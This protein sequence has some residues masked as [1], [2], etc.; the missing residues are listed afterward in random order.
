VEKLIKE[1]PFLIQGVAEYEIVE[2]LPS[3]TAPDLDGYREM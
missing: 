2:F 3:M 1:D